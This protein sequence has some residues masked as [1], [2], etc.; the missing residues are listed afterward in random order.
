ML[1]YWPVICKNVFS[2]DLYNGITLAIL[3]LFG[4][5][6]FEMKHYIYEEMA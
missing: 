5:H 3:I 6:L 4:K 1:L 2:P